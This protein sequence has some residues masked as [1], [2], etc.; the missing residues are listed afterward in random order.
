LTH[1]DSESG[2][3][4]SGTAEQL[5]FALPGTE[6]SKSKKL[7]FPKV[8]L[9]DLLIPSGTKEFGF[10]TFQKSTDGA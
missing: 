10:V 1:H 2:C 6:C 4:F 5:N 9:C 7:W 8:S 3:E